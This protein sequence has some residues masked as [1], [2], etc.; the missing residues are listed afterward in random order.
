MVRDAIKKTCG[1]AG[2]SGLDADGWC[3]TLISGNSGSSEGLRK[4]IAD[5]TKCLNITVKHLEAFLACGLIP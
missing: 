3:R 5:I 1:S 2:P 4:A